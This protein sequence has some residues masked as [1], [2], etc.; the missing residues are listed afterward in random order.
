[1]NRHFRRFL[2]TEETEKKFLV[3]YQLLVCAIC[4]SYFLRGCGKTFIGCLLDD[5]DGAHFIGF[6]QFSHKLEITFDQF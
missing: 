1:M 6:F 2:Q 5:V 3:I 4:C